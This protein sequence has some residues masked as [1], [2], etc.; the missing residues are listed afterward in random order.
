M[1]LAQR[2]EASIRFPTLAN[3]PVPCVRRAIPRSRD[4]FHSVVVV[5]RWSDVV[6]QSDV[7]RRSDE[8]HRLDIERRSDEGIFL[9]V[10]RP[11]LLLIHTSGESGERVLSHISVEDG[12]RP[13]SLDGD[14]KQEEASSQG[15]RLGCTLLDQAI[16]MECR[17]RQ[18]GKALEEESSRGNDR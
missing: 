15:T 4:W 17:L 7:A 8:V 18:W 2:V 16:G 12:Q 11:A 9:C 1:L 3:S 14:A 6:R 5:V 10:P 13:V